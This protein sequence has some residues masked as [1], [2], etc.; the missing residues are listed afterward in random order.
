MTTESL[1]IRAAAELIGTAGLLMVVIG[2]GVM[3]EQLANGNNAIA[4]LANALAT[5]CGLYVLILTLGPISGAHFNPSVT[6]AFALASRS[7]KTPT[8]WSEVGI[9]SAA[10]I[11][12]GVLGVWAA[13]I[14][15]DLPLWQWASKLRDGS[16][17]LFSEAIAT[18]GLLGTI[19]L[20]LRSSA[21]Q[22]APAVGAY[23]T[24]AY[25]FTASTSFANPAVT[26][27][28][29]LS[30]TF[31]GIRTADMPLFIAVQ[32]GTALLFGS[33]TLWLIRRRQDARAGLANGR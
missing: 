31:A 16:H 17:L 15:F 21:A 11:I 32:L 28:R 30:D 5:G 26:L 2:S 18:C 33:A 25:W 13:H 10:Q 23:I 7:A 24:T 4:L 22:V 29:T 9:Y 27:A 1:P 12:G 8:P 14:M 3:G 19:F 6:L 20:T